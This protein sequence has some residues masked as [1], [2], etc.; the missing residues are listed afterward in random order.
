MV[1]NTSCLLPHIHRIVYNSRWRACYFDIFIGISIRLIKNSSKMHTMH[2]C[3]ACKRALLERMTSN[4]I[5]NSSFRDTYKVPWTLH[6][7]AIFI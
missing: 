7:L 4:G 6:S 2:S 3:D 1:Q 5:Y